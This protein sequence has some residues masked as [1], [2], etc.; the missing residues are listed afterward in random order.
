MSISGIQ[1][2]APFA[3]RRADRIAERHERDRV[4]GWFLRLVVFGGNAFQE[5]PGFKGTLD[6]RW[7]LLAT[8]T[9]LE[10]STPVTRTPGL[11]LSSD[12]PSPEL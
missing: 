9:W 10:H 12:T 4:H 3:A 5:G 6:G 2:L 7:C 11:N 8:V 1:I